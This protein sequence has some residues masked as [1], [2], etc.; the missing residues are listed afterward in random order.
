LSSRRRYRAAIMSIFHARRK[1]SGARTPPEQGS[2]RSS[3]PPV[4]AAPSE[5]PPEQNMAHL[6]KARPVEYMLP[7]TIKWF[8][9]LPPQVRPVA[10]AAQYARI[11]NLLAP[12]WSDETACR[13]YFDE[14][15]T[16]RRGKRRGFPAHVRREL[17][18]LREHYLRLTSGRRPPLV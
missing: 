12:P 7:A 16:G 15:L 5:S 2:P 1:H 4:H 18:E 9:A 10:L 17:W 8:E 13:A 14:L 3:A 6:R 11:A